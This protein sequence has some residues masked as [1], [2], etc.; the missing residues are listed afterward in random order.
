M[1]HSRVEAQRLAV[2]CTEATRY[3]GNSLFDYLI[4]V[5]QEMDLKGAT[6]HRGICGFGHRHR[7]HHQHLLDLSCNLPVIVEVIDTERCLDGFLLA[8]ADAVSGCTYTLEN[9]L[10]H[11]P[12]QES[13][14]NG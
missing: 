9:L 10:W 12:E 1:S 7:L 11:Q 6:A 4:K 2:Y 13:S 3:Q 5:A 14:Q 8:V